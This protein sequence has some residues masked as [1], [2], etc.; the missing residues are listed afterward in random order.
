MFLLA[1]ILQLIKTL[2]TDFK[3][4]IK[5][6]KNIR[7]ILQLRL[8]FLNKYLNFK[9]RANRKNNLKKNKAQVFQCNY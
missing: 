7:K 8:I 3:N 2:L 9:I 1:V 5:Y 6:Y 4:K